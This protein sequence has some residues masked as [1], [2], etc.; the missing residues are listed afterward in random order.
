MKKYICFVC[1]AELTE[2]KMGTRIYPNCGL[3]PDDNSIAEKE[4]KTERTRSY[5]G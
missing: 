5:L 4:D 3:R 2:T 1:G